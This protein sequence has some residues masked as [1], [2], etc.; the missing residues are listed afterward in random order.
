[1]NGKKKLHEPNH[2]VNASPVAQQRH[3]DS[4]GISG[5]PAMN[6]SGVNP[7]SLSNVILVHGLPGPPWAIFNHSSATSLRERDSG[8]SPPAF[9]HSL[10]NG[11]QRASQT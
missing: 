4:A 8:Q 2:S 6:F 1:M 10:R 11:S 9:S 5:R 7:P 3:F